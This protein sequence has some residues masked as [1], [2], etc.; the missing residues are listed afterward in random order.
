[1][2]LAMAELLRLAKEDEWIAL[3]NLSNSVVVFNDA[4]LNVDLTFE[5]A[6][7]PQGKDVQECSAAVL[8]NPGM[9]RSV[10]LGV[11]ELVDAPEVLQEALDR[12]RA[13]YRA[14]QRRE[15]D[16]ASLPH[17]AKDRTV[18][19]GKACIAPGP[20]GELCGSFAL[21]MSNDATERPPLC[22]EHQHMA[23]QYVMVQTEMLGPD[24]EPEYVWRRASL[25]RSRG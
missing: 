8:K 1:M 18:A 12:Q 24:G 23:N 16:L 2:P 6:N 17:S 14:R 21:V 7:D 19:T 11:L 10:N 9:L 13:D 5:P 25:I 22:G 4:N 3:R 15:A 20:R